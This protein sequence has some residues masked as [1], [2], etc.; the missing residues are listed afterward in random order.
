MIAAT[1]GGDYKAER[2]VYTTGQPLESGQRSR[3]G[4]YAIM[5]VEKNFALRISLNRDIAAMY[6]ECDSR[7]LAEAW[8]ERINNDLD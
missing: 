2:F 6:N 8:L 7:Y 5:S 1:L 3:S 4:L